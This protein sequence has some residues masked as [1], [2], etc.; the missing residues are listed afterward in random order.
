VT[1]KTQEIRL[2]QV[3]EGGVNLNEALS[4]TTGGM[5]PVLAVGQC[6]A[7]EMSPLV[8]NAR[9]AEISWHAW[10]LHVAIVGLW[11]E[12]SKKPAYVCY[13]LHSQVVRLFLCCHQKRYANHFYNVIEQTPGYMECGRDGFPP[14]RARPLAYWDPP[15]TAVALWPSGTTG[16]TDGARVVD[17]GN[18]MAYFS[19]PETDHAESI[20]VDKAGPDYLRVPAEEHAEFRWDRRTYRYLNRWAAVLMDLKVEL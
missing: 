7:I 11:S 5:P 3:A 20:P 17:T 9:K 13:T 16:A 2:S 8:E 19:Y 10:L 4:A 12:N 15:C 6:Y 14:A 18:A 1:L